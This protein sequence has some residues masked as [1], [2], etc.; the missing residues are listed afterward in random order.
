MAETPG[1]E[2]GA[3]GPPTAIEPK[4]LAENAVLKFVQRPRIM[5]ILLGAWNVVAAVSE[6]F[7]D[8]HNGKI[9][10]PVGGL[11]LSWESIPLAALY[12]YCAREPERYQRVF[13]LALIQQAAAVVANFYHWGADD[14]TPGSIVIPVAVSATLGALVFLHLF[15]PKPAEPAAPASTPE[16]AGSG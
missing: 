7:V 12:F 1:G 6:F 13:W 5:L 9:R 15:Q 2:T 14:V 16:A 8:V 4:Q 11:A 10:G 3:A